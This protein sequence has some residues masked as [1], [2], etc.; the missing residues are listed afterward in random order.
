MSAAPDAWS[1]VEVRGGSASFD[2]ATN[3]SA[4]VVHGKSSELDARASVRDGAD[5]L[6]Q[7]SDKASW[8]P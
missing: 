3:I 5:G 1:I 7:K 6:V 2:A 4:I 8:L